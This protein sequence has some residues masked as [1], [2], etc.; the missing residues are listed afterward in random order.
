MRAKH[1]TLVILLLLLAHNV[2]DAQRVVR[3]VGGRV[4]EEEPAKAAPA[5]DPNAVAAIEPTPEERESLL[6]LIEELG[7]GSIA[8][9]ERAMSEIASFEAKALRAIRDA[10]EH[11]NDEIAWRCALLEEVILS[12]QGELFLAARRMNMTITELNG[13]LQNADVS[14]LL[15]LLRARGQPGMVALWS[16]VLGRLASRTEIFPAAR[17]CREVEGV[18]GYGS[19]LLRATASPQFAE[20]PFLLL[21]LVLVLPPAEARDTVEILARAHLAL[22]GQSSQEF[23]ARACIG[24]RGVFTPADCLAAT[25]GR[26]EADRRAPADAAAARELADLRTAIALA[27]VETADAQALA[28]AQVPPLLAMSPLVLDAWLSLL[29]RSGQGAR[30]ESA[31]IEL[32]G[33]NADSRRVS[34]AAASMARGADIT[35]LA[36]FFADL[37]PHA[38]LAMLDAW[39]LNPR[40]PEVL[41]PFLVTLLDDPLHGIRA[42]A[43]RVLSQLRAPS[44]VKALARCALA[45]PDTAPTCLEALVPMAELLPTADPESWGKL[46]ASVASANADKR[47]GIA[48]LQL[49]ARSGHPD[50]TNA[51]LKLWK[52]FLPRNELALCVS[53][54]ARDTSTVAGAYAS[55]LMAHAAANLSAPEYMLAELGPDTFALLTLLL[56]LDDEAG[57]ALLRELAAD[58]DDM[59]RLTAMGALAIAGREGDLIEGWI[60]I[61][62]GETPDS[63]GDD[64]AF[65]VAL[66]HTPQADA[67]RRQQLAR[68]SRS[69]AFMSLFLSVARGVGT[70]TAD[71]LSAAVTAR[72]EE[73]PMFLAHLQALRRPLSEAALN[74]LARERAFGEDRGFLSSA[75]VALELAGRDF[76]VI[77]LLY[78]SQEKP[79]PATIDH[80]FATVLM[81]KRDRAAAIVSALKPKE[82]GSDFVPL[83][84]A[85]ALLDLESPADNKRL[86]R[87][88]LHEPGGGIGAWLNYAAARQGDLHALRRLIDP[89]SASAA[90][91]AQG[92]SATAALEEERWGGSQLRLDAVATSFAT[93]RSRISDL[94]SALAPLLPGAGTDWQGWW[95]CRRGLLQWD[96]ASA[97][98]RIK[99]LP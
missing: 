8:R 4:V 95:H 52:Q 91:F 99:E 10:K 37:P 11:D 93:G 89:I 78:G 26:P 76:D 96:A 22:R 54:L 27:M 42:A 18:A 20:M 5:I 14:P 33:G 45:N 15:S 49:M 62:K 68:P 73:L 35:A 80:L 3:I 39:W 67:F 13:H 46:L 58:P 9:R 6:G 87:H 64:V 61:V 51:L 74:A 97:S 29:A 47:P 34:L 31:M 98:Y 36:G 70:V 38:R 66:S 79:E 72:P 32:I 48:L 19:A 65:G 71:E 40:Q 30:I 56:R 63:D 44:T 59:E 43:A 69:D 57:F 88:E 28:R 85:R 12:G 84:Y 25:V 50:A 7:A 16:N 90:S 23:V 24:L 53:V 75:Y 21:T 86:A 55:A 83:L 2:A 77:E 94:P 81:G 17:I 41:Q 1:L 82:D 92:N 60:K